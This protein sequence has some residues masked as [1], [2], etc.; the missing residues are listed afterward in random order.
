MSLPVADECLCEGRGMYRPPDSNYYVWCA[1]KRQE[2]SGNWPLHCVQNLGVPIDVLDRL[3]FDTWI[4]SINPGCNDDMRTVYNWCSR[5]TASPW[6]LV[7]GEK[8]LGKTH[9]LIAA[10]GYLAASGVET[11]YYTAKDL[12]VALRDSLNDG[13]TAEVRQRL[14]TIRA[15]V[16]D[17]LG[18]EHGT[19]WIESEIHGILDKRYVERRRTLLATNKTSL[20]DFPPRLA[21]RLTD[22]ITVTVLALEGRDARPY[23]ADMR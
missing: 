11:A 17:D 15:L 12:E 19:D 5:D 10:A 14:Q 21:S 4:P 13:S 18:A 7:Q 9:L 1:C 2:V 16:V 20:R 6:L 22:G 3:K 8:G 23:L